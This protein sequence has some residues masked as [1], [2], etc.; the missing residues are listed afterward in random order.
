MWDCHCICMKVLYLFLQL[1]A[2]WGRFFFALR[3]A[4]DALSERGGAGRVACLCFCDP[5]SR[6][7]RLG[8]SLAL[9]VV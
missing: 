2:P 8:P 4:P 3:T 6:L 9:F 5:L 1:L 7:A